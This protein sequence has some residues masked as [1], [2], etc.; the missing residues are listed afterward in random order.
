MV[1]RSSATA[2]VTADAPLDRRVERLNDAIKVM[3]TSLPGK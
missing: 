2:E 1:W 3:F